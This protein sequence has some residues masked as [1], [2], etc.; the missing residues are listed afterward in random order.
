MGG[1]EVYGTSVKF[2]DYS[3]KMG[4]QSGETLTLR[5]LLYGLML[6]SGNDAAE[7]I[8]KHVSGSVDGF[9]ELMNQKAAALG[10]AGTR[11]ANPHG[12]PNDNHNTRRDM[13]NHM[14]MR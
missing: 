5:D 3:S 10:M 4:I 11:F 12:V 14:H 13:A 7:A 9:V 2:T 1:E 6:A 8:A